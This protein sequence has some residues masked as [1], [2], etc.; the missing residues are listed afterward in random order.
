MKQCMTYLQ[1]SRKRMIQLG[2]KGLYNTLIELSISM[3]LV[4][5]IRICFNET[6]SRVP[7]SKHLNDMFAIMNSLKIGDALSPLIFN[8]VLKYAFRRVQVNRHGLK[9]SGNIIL[10]LMV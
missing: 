8:F 10:L 1:T 9:L 2:G 4:R 7:A 3:K 5:P 6:Y